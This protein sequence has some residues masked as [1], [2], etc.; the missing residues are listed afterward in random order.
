VL[1][2]FKVVVFLPFLLLL[3]FLVDA[4]F[5]AAWEISVES[6]LETSGNTVLMYDSNL[7][8]VAA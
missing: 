2:V 1:L 3:G 5:L 4:T 7:A 8:V 6:F